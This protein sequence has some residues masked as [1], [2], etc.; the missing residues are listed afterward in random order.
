MSN[1]L[2][3]RISSS[4]GGYGENVEAF[5]PKKKSDKKSAI[6]GES[7]RLSSGVVSR[8]TRELPVFVIMHRN[9]LPKQEFDYF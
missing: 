7:C 3:N 6:N 1:L 9:L 2:S 8:I 5:S 4:G